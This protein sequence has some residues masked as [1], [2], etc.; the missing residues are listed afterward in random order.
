MS[1]FK[2]YHAII[3]CFFLAGLLGC[4]PVKQPRNLSGKTDAGQYRVAIEL[5][6]GSV[7]L[8]D[9][10]LEQLSSCSLDAYQWKK[11][12][13]LFGAA[14]DTTGISTLIRKTNIQVE[15]RYYNTPMYV[16][17]KAQNCG[18]TTLASPWTDYLMTANLVDDSVAQSEYIH[19][20]AVQFDEWPEVAQG[21]CRANFQQLLVFRNGRQL[22]LVISVPAGKTL[23]ELD[24]KTVQ[25]NPRMVEWN[26]QMS[27][28]Q[29]GIEG[30]S[31]DETWVFLE[32]RK[33]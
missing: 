2:P 12:V 13:V 26:E 27:G 18:D 29:V 4:S 3:G 15:V 19:Y 24:P 25:N 22:L 17:D 11:H 8:A 16:F 32:K 31:P 33:Q 6:A 30:T 10:L 23:D 21:F 5:V 9:S 20:H 14:A 1:L 28:Y 7:G